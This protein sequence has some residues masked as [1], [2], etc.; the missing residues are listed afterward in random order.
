MTLPWRRFLFA[1]PGFA[2]DTISA[3]IG[4]YNNTLYIRVAPFHARCSSVEF[5][6]VYQ[7]TNAAAAHS[8]IVSFGQSVRRGC[9]IRITFNTKYI[10]MVCVLKF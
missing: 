3:M 8:A 2:T 6:F 10:Y 5:F 1:R 9:A 4:T 7:G